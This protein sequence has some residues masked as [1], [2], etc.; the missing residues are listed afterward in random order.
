MEITTQFECG[1]GK[2]VR[3][4][5]KNEFVLETDGSDPRY[6]FYF[7]FKV[8]GDDQ[9]QDV[10]ITLLPDSEY[11]RAEPDLFDDDR[12]SV[13]WIRRDKFGWTRMNHHW[14]FVD[15]DSFQVEKSRY[16]IHLRIEPHSEV[17]VSNMLPLP[18]STMCSWLR[19]VSTS[20]PDLAQLTDVGSS[21]QERPILGLR[22]SEK[23]AGRGGK[24]KRRMLA[25]AGEH[26]AEFAGQWAMKGLI[27]FCLSSVAEAQK[28]R[29]DWEVLF[30]PQVNPDGNVL[31]KLHNVYRTNLHLDYGLEQGLVRPKSKEARVLWEL[32]AS[33]EP[34]ICLCAHT[35]I[36]PLLSSD[37]PYEGLIVPAPD[38]FGDEEAQ[39]RQ[40][41][42]ND[43]LSWYTEVSHFW[44][45]EDLLKKADPSSLV[46]RLSSQF[47]TVGCIFEPNMSVGEMGCVRN[48]LKVVRALV[49]AFEQRGRPRNP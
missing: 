37:P 1:S 48:M 38:C 23:A 29:E 14:V 31:G 36:G 17:E 46:S 11:A 20:R 15:R 22:V 10:T 42:A 45:R 4:V 39:R 40:E 35:F 41:R 25:F 18:Y 26:A 12:P 21:E 32:A 28:L 9:R 33:F 19:D 24:S 6:S 16:T 13:L 49:A 34:D 27:E 5:S 8:K 47:G 30:A 43:Y 7:Y 3:E 44:G 2:N